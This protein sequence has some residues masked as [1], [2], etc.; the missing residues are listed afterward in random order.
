MALIV[1][2]GSIVAGANSYAALAGANAYHTARANAAWTGTDAAK[3]AALIRATEFL[4]ASYWWRG[5]IASEDQ[6]LRWPRSGVIDR[7]GREIAA[8]DLPT[9]IQRATFELA[10]IA[11]SGALIGGD[12]G[13]TSTAGGAIKRVKAGSVEV[14]YQAGQV[15]QSPAAASNALPDGKAEM[16]DR[17]LSGLYAAPS[18]YMTKLLKS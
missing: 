1:E 12:A 15:S 9:Q 14:E 5:Q 2:D 16:I 8:D 13:S 4:D 17:I 6:A 18:R 10:L 7:D 11:L 3:E